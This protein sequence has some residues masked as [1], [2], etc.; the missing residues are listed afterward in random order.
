MTSSRCLHKGRQNWVAKLA[1]R[2]LNA[3]RIPT[4][5][6]YLVSFMDT[7]PT[8]IINNSSSNPTGKWSTIEDTHINYQNENSIKM[9][10]IIKFTL[11]LSQSMPTKAL[12]QILLKL[13]KNKKK[14]RM[15]KSPTKLHQAR[16]LLLRSRKIINSNRL[17]INLYK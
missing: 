9:Q 4:L 16:K 8:N 10:R 6:Q 3:V 17:K 5:V 12:T 14:T 2:C 15:R 13:N 7:I 11:L 1:V